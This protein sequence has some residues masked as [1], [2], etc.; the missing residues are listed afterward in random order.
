[1]KINRL[2]LVVAFGF[3][4][5]TALIAWKSTRAYVVN[6]TWSTNTASFTYDPSLPT[7][8]Y[9]GVSSGAYAW[10]DVGTSSWAWYNSPSGGNWMKYGYIDG[11]GNAAAGM[12]PTICNP[13]GH[14]CKI[15][16][17]F[18]SGEYWYTGSGTPLSYQVDLRSVATHE[19]GHALGLGHTQTMP[20]CPGNV[21]DATMCPSLPAGTTYFR[22]LQ[23]DDRLAVSTVYP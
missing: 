11:N 17:K 6:Y 14:L 19:F 7:G 5:V 10:N 15:E 1:M 21:S 20:N 16:I 3:A 8:F 9:S 22:S 23:G 2:Q 12:T 13:G 4:L 18:E